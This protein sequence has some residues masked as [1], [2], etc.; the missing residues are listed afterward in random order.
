[1]KREDI[2]ED[3][4]IY[5]QDDGRYYFIQDVGDAV[6]LGYRGSG[7]HPHDELGYGIVDLVTGK[8]HDSICEHSH[9][10]STSLSVATEKDIN[11]YLANLEADAMIKLAKAKK[12]VAVALDAINKFE[13]LKK[14]TF[15]ETDKT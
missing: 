1:M 3:Q 13:K 8:I 14:K 9:M 2:K 15:D 7:N 6:D 4:L 5:N 11:I 10:T 12:R